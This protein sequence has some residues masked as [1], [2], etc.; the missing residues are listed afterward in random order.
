MHDPSDRRSL[1]LIIPKERTHWKITSKV[2]PTSHWACSCIISWWAFSRFATLVWTSLYLQTKFSINWLGQ[3]NGCGRL[4]LVSC[5]IGGGHCGLRYCS[6][7]LFFFSCSISWYH[8]AWW[9]AVFH[10]FGWWC[11]L[12]ESNSRYCGTVHTRSPFHTVNTLCSPNKVS[13]KGQ[14]LMDAT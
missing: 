1:I 9:Y 4:W 6:I 14:D 7:E 8:L 5:L 3:G 12:K 10:P 2:S 11:S 13:Y